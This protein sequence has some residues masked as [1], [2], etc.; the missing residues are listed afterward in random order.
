VEL[1]TSPFDECDRLTAEATAWVGRER[2]EE[3]A[4]DILGPF[5]LADLGDATRARLRLVSVCEQLESIPCSGRQPLRHHWCQALAVP[6]AADT[7]DEW[8]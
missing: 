5:D 7:L 1:M 8:T 3:A 6:V 2:V 4:A